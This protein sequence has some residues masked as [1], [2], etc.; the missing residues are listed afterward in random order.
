MPGRE[1]SIGKDHGKLKHSES[2]GQKT[3]VAGA[4][5]GAGSEKLGVTPGPGG[6]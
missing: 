5:T 4:V 2:S 6:R 3:C 1:N